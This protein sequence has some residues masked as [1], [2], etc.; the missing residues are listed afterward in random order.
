MPFSILELVE[1]SQTPAAESCSHAAA[2]GDGSKHSEEQASAGRRYADL[3]RKPKTTHQEILN[4]S[5]DLIP[6]GDA[7]KDFCLIR[8]LSSI[9]EPVERSQTPTAE[10]CSRS[11]SLSRGRKH[12]PQMPFSIL[13]LVERSQTPAAES[14]SRSSSLSRGR[15]L[16]PQMPFSILEL[17]ER[18]QTP[19]ANSYRKHLLQMLQFSRKGAADWT[20]SLWLGNYAGILR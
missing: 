7:N 18:S 12:L 10:S 4:R 13:E 2:R 1:R 20:D 6:N 3:L 5:L 9:L 11:S 8:I 15:K 16:L 14:C 17:V 19:A